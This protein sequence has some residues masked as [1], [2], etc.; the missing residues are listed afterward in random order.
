MLTDPAYRERFRRN[1]VAAARE[2][3]VAGVADE[4]AMGAGKAMD[5]LDGRES[6][7][8]LAGV[9]MAAALE[10]AG[11]YDFSKDLAPHLRGSRSRSSRCCRASTPRA[12]AR[13]G[14]PTSA[15][16]GRVTPLTEAAA[17]FP[18]RRPTPRRVHA[19]SRPSRRPPA[20]GGRRAA[21]ARGG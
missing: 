11:V 8:S 9:F 2:A 21:G 19:R 12:V 16:R 5:T 17:G 4:M 15:S 3:G 7:S 6:R 10:G 18:R 13:P 1:P 14:S 20:L